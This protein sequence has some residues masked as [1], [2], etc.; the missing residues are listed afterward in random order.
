VIANFY[1]VNTATMADLVA[2]VSSL[3][4]TWGR[5]GQKSALASKQELASTHH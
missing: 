5:L 2:D 1:V 4:A 3:R